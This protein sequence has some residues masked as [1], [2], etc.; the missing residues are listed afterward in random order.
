MVL[1]KGRRLQKPRLQRRLA[2]RDGLV[3][4]LTLD[5]STSQGGKCSCLSSTFQYAAN[6]S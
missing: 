6:E 2:F 5:Y 4:A 1:A 3:R